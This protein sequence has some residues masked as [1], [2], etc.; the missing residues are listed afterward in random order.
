MATETTIPARI[1]RL[2]PNRRGAVFVYAGLIL[3][4]AFLFG[5]VLGKLESCTLPF[6]IPLTLA[7][8][9]FFRLAYHIRLEV[10]PEGIE[11]FQMGYRLKTTWDNIERIGMIPMGLLM[12]E[13]LILRESALQ[14]K[15]F[16]RKNLERNRLD[17]AIPLTLFQ[18]WWREG[19]LGEEIKR[20]A[21][22][23]IVSG[24]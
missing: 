21:P 18:P 22:R 16:G 12:A 5:V 7:S 2:E 9:Y 17:R 19:D 4:F 15:I 14:G 11:Y 23:L 1:Y 20:Y 6:V 24:N 10:S 13:G 8:A 3:L